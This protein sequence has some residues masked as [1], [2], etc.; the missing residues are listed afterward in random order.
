[1]VFAQNNNVIETFPPDRP[2]KAFNENV[3]PR[4]LASGNSLRNAHHAQSILESSTIERVK[5]TY[6]TAM[7]LRHEQG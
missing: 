2:D 5:E 3:L 4:R 1:M 7:R 6:E